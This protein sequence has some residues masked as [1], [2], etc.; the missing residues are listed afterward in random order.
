MRSVALM[1]ANLSSGQVAT[2]TTRTS[3]IA[4]INAGPGKAMLSARNRLARMSPAT[5]RCGGG[6]AVGVVTGAVDG[7]TRNGTGTTYRR[8]SS[9]A[10]TV[11]TSVLDWLAVANPSADAAAAPGVAGFCSAV[12]APGT[13]ART[14]DRMLLMRLPVAID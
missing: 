4:V 11:D 2:I 3:T 7:R 1:V 12:V 13:A 10:I 9:P 5:I 6:A 14:A 8:Y